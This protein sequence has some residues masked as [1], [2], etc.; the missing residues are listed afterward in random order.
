MAKKIIGEIIKD[1]VNRQG[2][3]AE[4][5]GYKIN[6]ERENVYKIYKRTN[7]SILQLQQISKA[8]DHNFFEDIINNNIE[9]EDPKIMKEFNNRRAVSQFME[10][11]PVTLEEL[12]R[13]PIISFGRPI[14]LNKGIQTPD[15]I[16]TDYWISFTIG[17]T[18]MER[19]PVHCNQS[20]VKYEKIRNNENIEIEVLINEYVLQERPNSNPIQINIKLDYK[21]KD[22]W[23]KTL[24]FAFE[25]YDYFQK[26]YRIRL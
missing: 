12:N 24:K 25:L 6:C 2:L 18:F 4:E 8:L 5:F 7:M 15:F 17:E 3:K 11:V 20:C 19:S 16:L 1:E 10:I 26:Q 13:S 21:T 22:E 9:M 14:E 23:T